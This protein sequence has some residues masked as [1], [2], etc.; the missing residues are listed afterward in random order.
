MNDVVSRVGLGDHEMVSFVGGGGK[1]TLLHTFASSLTGTR[2][3]TTTTKMDP[4]ESGE[5]PTLVGA[6]D[7]EIVLA[8]AAGPVLAWRTL[9][10][11]KAV[12][13]ETSR[14][15]TLFG[16]VDHVLVEADGARS[17]PF[18]APGPFEPNVPS[19]TTVMISVIGADALGRV[20]ADQCHR[21]LR[22]AALANCGPYERLSPE[23]AA[24]VL[25]HPRGQRAALVEHGRLIIAVTKVDEVN[26]DFVEALVEE[27]ARLEPAL[28]VIPVARTAGTR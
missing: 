11:G 5:L 7:D 10:D 9:T 26:A 17:M 20:I 3:A 19:L 4:G 25:L 15:N 14:C 28:A 18:K 23:A 21:P 6:S 27:V 22:V 2:I 13:L 24:T 16:R 1:T 12:G 8:A